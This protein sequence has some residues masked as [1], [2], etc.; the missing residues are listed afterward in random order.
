MLFSTN[1]GK[2]N[3]A[4]IKAGDWLLPGRAGLNVYRIEANVNPEVGFFPS[5]FGFGSVGILGLFV[6]LGVILS[7]PKLANAAR[8]SIMS[9]R[10]GGF[11]FDSTGTMVGATGVGRHG[12]QA[13]SVGA[14]AMANRAA[15]KGGEGAGRGWS[16]LSKGIKT[17]SSQ[18]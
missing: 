8:D 7:I 1:T 2:L 5:G 13:G 6:S 10:M 17:V 14:E 9:G 15:S 16:A 12:Y 11:G 3:Q 18:K 4:L